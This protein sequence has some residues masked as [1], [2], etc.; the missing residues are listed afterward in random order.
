MKE[1]KYNAKDQSFELPDNFLESIEIKGDKGKYW[2]EQ[3][4]SL[5]D[6]K[7]EI[8][9]KKSDI[10]KLL[11]KYI[12]HVMD[13]NSVDFILRDANQSW[14]SVKFSEEELSTLH[15]LRKTDNDDI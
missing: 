13:M 12:E 15:R 2:F 14:A 3:Y 1:I 9:K 5:L 6:E 8:D 7:N 11:A 4:L 10:E